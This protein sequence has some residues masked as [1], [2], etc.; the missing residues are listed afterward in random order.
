MTVSQL[1]TKLQ[2]CNPNARVLT[3]KSGFL[4]VNQ[5]GVN[6]SDVM[7]EAILVA[8]GVS[9]KV[10]QENGGVGYWV[11]HEPWRHDWA[12]APLMGE[13][14]VYIGSGDSIITPLWEK[15]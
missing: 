8:Q 10:F 2:T 6:I 5:I 1:I 3:D 7:S 4:E 15:K 11:T 13:P 14:S 12:G 9:Y